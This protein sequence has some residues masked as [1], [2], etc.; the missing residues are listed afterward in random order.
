MA[1]VDQAE[2]YA[3]VFE[4]C[5]SFLNYCTKA[6]YEHDVEAPDRDGLNLAYLQEIQ[7]NF[8]EKELQQ[9]V[10]L[11]EQPISVQRF[12]TTYSSHDFL[13]VLGELF[14]LL[15]EFEELTD[16]QV[17]IQ[18]KNILSKY[19]SMNVDILYS[20]KIHTRIRGVRG[21]QK[22]YQDV[23]YKKHQVIFD[24]MLNKAKEQGKWQNLNA[25]VDSVLSE[26]DIVLKQ[27]DKEWI[28]K[29]LVEKT[30]EMKKL[31]QEF[32]QY[33]VNPP[34]Y[35]LGSGIT[36]AATREQ[37]YINKI[38]ELRVACRDFKN[39]LQMD[40]PSILL[41]KQLPFNTAYQPEVIKN[42]L[43]KQPSL[44]DEIIQTA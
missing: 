39:A 35:K 37:T 6:S 32:K 43:R 38:R 33:K 21:A 10:E 7:R 4:V 22:R 25:A 27:F 14:N 40:D 12:N 41:K 2:L 18:Y 20:Q 30:K 17:K 13:E 26:L 42:L 15:N 16:K 23:L 8:N 1:Y 11:M 3:F 24:F 28:A 44:L 31:Q 34:S 9:I 36:M 29:Q 5:Q 19:A